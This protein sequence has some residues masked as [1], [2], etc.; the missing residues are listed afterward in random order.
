VFVMMLNDLCCHGF[1]GFPAA[2]IDMGLTAV[3]VTMCG[4]VWSPGLGAGNLNV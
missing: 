1:V 4:Q 2:G 3:I